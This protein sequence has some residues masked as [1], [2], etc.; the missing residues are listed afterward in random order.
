MKENITDN[1][2]NK[3][4]NLEEMNTCL[5]TYSFTKLNQKQSLNTPITTNGIEAPIK[6]LPTSKIPGP[7]SFTSEFSKKNKLLRKN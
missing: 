3:L 4:D 6:K 5:E 1:Y 2:I 7:D